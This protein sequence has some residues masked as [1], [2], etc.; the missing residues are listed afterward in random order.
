MPGFDV[1]GVVLSSGKQW[2]PVQHKPEQ[3]GLASHKPGHVHS[4][5]QLV[6]RE[7]W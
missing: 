3:R 1:C 2:Q 4:C 7:R 5:V 6:V